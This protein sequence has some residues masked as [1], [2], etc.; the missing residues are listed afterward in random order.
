MCMDEMTCG[1]QHRAISHGHDTHRSEEAASI[2]MQGLAKLNTAPYEPF[3]RSLFDP[4]MVDPLEEVACQVRSAGCDVYVPRE[5]C[6]R[7]H[8]KLLIRGPSKPLTRRDHT[9]LKNSINDILT[10]DFLYQGP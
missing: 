4:D 1:K 6:P 9:H 2:A 10:G 3:A 5:S 7:Q 8:L